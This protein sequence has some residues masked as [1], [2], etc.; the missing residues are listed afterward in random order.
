[1]TEKRIRW[2]KW[3]EST[4]RVVGLVVSYDMIMF[5][6]SGRIYA[7]YLDTINPENY[8]LDAAAWIGIR[9]DHELGPYPLNS[10]QWGG[11]R[12]SSPSMEF[13]FTYDGYCWGWKGKRLAISDI[14]EEMWRRKVWFSVADRDY[15][16]NHIMTS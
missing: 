6:K 3:R 14:H 8:H 13:A 5:D 1:M 15:I 16:Y 9:M 2:I 10:N 7:D 11:F 4:V 12:N